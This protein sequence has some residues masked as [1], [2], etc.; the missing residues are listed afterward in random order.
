MTTKRQGADVS[1]VNPFEPVTA[2]DFRHRVRGWWR[3]VGVSG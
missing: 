1:G 2:R 3:L